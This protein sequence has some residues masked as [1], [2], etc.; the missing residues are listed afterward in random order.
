MTGPRPCAG[1]FV[2]R[3]LATGDVEAARRFYSALLGWTWKGEETGDVGTYWLG[4][5]GGRQVCGTVQK[6]PGWTAPSAWSSYVLVDDVDAAVGMAEASG[7]KALHAPD[8]IPGVGRFAVIADPWGAVV[9]P[10]H[11]SGG[12][13]SP[14]PMPPPPGH[15][16]WETL[17]TPDPA[18]AIDFYGKVIGMGTGRTPD[19]RGTVFTAGDAPVADLQPGRPG[20]PAY[21]ATY[22]AVEDA[23]R[24]RDQA[25][26]LGGTILVPRVDVP[27]VGTVAVVA[28]PDGAAL[29]LFQPLPRR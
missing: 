27:M 16:C 15:F 10:F 19:G 13:E 20:A 8:D 21:W 3:E 11:P 24:S 18:G 7:G 12:E 29:G 2:W 9:M 23:V 14:P 28:D 22:V 4:S 5:A 17:V 6:L 26:A 25:A 1:T